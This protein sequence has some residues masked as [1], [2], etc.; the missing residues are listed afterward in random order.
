[1]FNIK[2]PL[3]LIFLV[4]LGGDVILLFMNEI[5]SYRR[6]HSALPLTLS[7]SLTLKAQQW[8]EH[9]AE[10]DKYVLKCVLIHDDFIVVKIFSTIV[11]VRQAF[12]HIRT[13]LTLSFLF[14]GLHVIGKTLV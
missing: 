13:L 14:I 1:M 8:A 9:L 3:I 5:N 12:V 10:L 7:T 4:A 11:I 2:L 6:M